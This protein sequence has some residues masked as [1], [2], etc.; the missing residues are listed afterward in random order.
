MHQIPSIPQ[1]SSTFTRVQVST[2]L[3]TAPSSNRSSFYSIRITSSG[4][5]FATTMTT[6][7]TTTAERNGSSIDDRRTKWISTVLYSTV[8]R[9][10]ESC[11]VGRRLQAPPRA[12]SPIGQRSH[13]TM[14][15]GGGIWHPSPAHSR[16]LYPTRH[17]TVAGFIH[18]HSALEPYTNA[19]RQA[20]SRT[21]GL[22]MCH[23]YS[24]GLCIQAT[25]RGCAVPYRLSTC[26]WIGHAH[27]HEDEVISCRS[28]GS[29]RFLRVE[30]RARTR[31]ALDRS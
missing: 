27:N 8:S 9:K 18:P 14:H 4:P 6:T 2:L 17:P 5:V 26:S 28:R 31:L 10:T 21:C 20:P 22:S 24:K 19:T 25:M 16:R 29:R 3:K 30:S 13:G 12:G 7:A 15:A 11:H 23:E 1:V